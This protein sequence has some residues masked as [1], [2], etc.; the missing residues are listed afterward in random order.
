MT[1]K[2]ILIVEDDIL[3]ARILA[4][5]LTKLG[6]SV[7]DITKSADEAIL[8]S[9]QHTPDLVMM[10]IELEGKADGISAAKYIYLFFSIPVVFCTA[11]FGGEVIKKAKE[12]LP[13][14]F[15]SKPF[16][17][18]DLFNSIEIALNSYEAY[19]QTGMDSKTFKEVIHIDLGV[20]FLDVDGKI[21]FINPYAE[22]LTG[23]SYKK[24]FY[25]NIDEVIAY[26]AGSTTG[27]RHSSLL[28]TIREVSAIGRGIE[29]VIK[30]KIF[31]KR[32]AMQMNAKPRKDKRG[33]IIGYMVKLEEDFKRTRAL[34]EKT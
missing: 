3:I 9:I 21:I 20:I 10:D 33:Q 4:D 23:I 12:A 24:A 18:R 6:Y 14:G 16:D 34:N 15:V 32:K 11:H 22:H 17:D 8:H 26:D 1:A 7:S 25:E 2:Q 19:K 13:F 27:S 31:G 5:R 29:I 30:T 28:D